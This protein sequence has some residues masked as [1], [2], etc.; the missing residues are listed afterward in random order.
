MKKKVRARNPMNWQTRVAMS[1]DPGAWSK[2]VKWSARVA[3]RRARA[4]AQ[5]QNSRKE[6]ANATCKP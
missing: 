6:K 1:I 2:N 5:A 3:E 4:R